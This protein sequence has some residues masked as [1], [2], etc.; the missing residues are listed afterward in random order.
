MS[1]L[2]FSDNVVISDKRPLRKTKDGYLVA[3]VHAARTG[4]QD[5]LGSEVGRPDKDIVRVYRPT[6]EV[7]KKDS[8]GTYKGKPITMGHPSE[9]VTA[10]NHKDLSRGHI[11]SVAR[12]G[13]AVALDV[14]I[15]D[16]ETI[17]AIE[18]K[19]GPRE[20]SAGY[21][22]NI[23][24]TPGKTEDGQVYDAV[25]RNIFV[26]H[27]AIVDAGRA[28]KEFRIGDDAEW[29][30][31]PLISD[32]IEPKKEDHM[33]D[34]LKATVQVGDNAVRTD[35]VGAVHLKAALKDAAKNAKA[36]TDSEAKVAD[37]TK[38]LATRDGELEA[39]KKALDEATSPEAIADRVKKRGE[40]MEKGKKAGLEEDD[41]EKAS[42]EAIAKAIVAK[43]L[44][45]E[46][47]KQNDKADFMVVADSITAY[48]DKAPKKTSDAKFAD[49]VKSKGTSIF[50]DG[51]LK[52]AG[53]KLKK[54][55]A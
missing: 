7:F 32:S 45:D 50:S 26:D 51:L 16:G 6:D 13:E 41:M 33:S 22:A 38:T 31:R 17:K 20:L 4:I 48:D 25:Q 42:D 29:G 5:Y 55:E 52:T 34:A 44:G 10:D 8:L 2:K 30:V 35:D 36:L 54:E 40:I 27:L 23:D 12:D 1:E 21:V 15:T 18:A 19:D 47:V 3:R 9:R 53:V 24:W 28:G 14:A 39:A 43:H 49:G 37:L 11:A 46:W